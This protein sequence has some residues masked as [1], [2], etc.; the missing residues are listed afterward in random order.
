MKS[1]QLHGST[2]RVM[3]CMHSSKCCVAD[4]LTV[5]LWRDY[6]AHRH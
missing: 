1:K 6:S 4:I 5:D 3:K 2:L